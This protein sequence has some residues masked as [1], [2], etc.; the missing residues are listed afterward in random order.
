[1][2]FS[3][4]LLTD[5]R[6][7][8]G[9]AAWGLNIISLFKWPSPQTVVPG[10]THGCLFYVHT[11]PIT[12]PPLQ[13]AVTMTQNL[14]ATKSSQIALFLLQALSGQPASLMVHFSNGDLAPLLR[15]AILLSYTTFHLQFSIPWTFLP[16]HQHL[17]RLRQFLGSSAIADSFSHSS[18]RRLQSPGEGMGQLY[19]SQPY[20]V[21]RHLSVL[22]NTKQSFLYANEH[23][24]HVLYLFF[25][26][27]TLKPLGGWY[28]K[29]SK[30]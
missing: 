7:C 25:F 16:R 11:L 17:A 1:M 3:M 5:F 28:E 10:D 22:K 6:L 13:L 23:C 14:V 8:Q 26:S 30:P 4:I 20:A 18:T 27:V 21:T 2:L 12:I 15:S 19:S 9:I 24:W 29:I